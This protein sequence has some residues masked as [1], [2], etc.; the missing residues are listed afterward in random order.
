MR[1]DDDARQDGWVVA[2]S[3]H[4]S[5]RGCLV[6]FAAVAARS[7]MIERLRREAAFP[8]D[9]LSDEQ[10]IDECTPEE[11]L[12]CKEIRAAIRA[13]IGRLRPSAEEMRVATL[14][15][16][17][18]RALTGSERIA[19]FRLSAKAKRSHEMRDLAVE[20]GVRV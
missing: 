18:D 2:L 8:H 17:E 7:R 13:A 1:L 6:G 10:L 15:M 11:A 3:R 5:R 14:I 4:D 20:I 19:K 12:V 9:A 16:G